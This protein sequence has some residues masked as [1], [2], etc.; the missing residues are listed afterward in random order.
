MARLKPREAVVRLRERLTGEP[1]RQRFIML[2]REAIGEAEAINHRATGQRIGYETIVDGRR[3]AAIESVKPGGVVVA[4]FAVHAAAIDFTWETLAGLSPVDQNPKTV[5][6]IV[7][8]E[9]HLLLVNG[10]EREPPVNVEPDD[11]V[12]FVN[13]LPYARRIEHGYSKKQAPDGVYEVATA[14]VKARYGN[15]VDVKF[16]YGSFLG[17]TASRDTRY[18][19]IQLSPKRRR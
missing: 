9:N 13:L 18:P 8:R 6:N 12:T 17:A 16:G 2:A 19:F 7:Y 4:L 1:R 3:N 14:I 11:I 5:D 15:I 10:E